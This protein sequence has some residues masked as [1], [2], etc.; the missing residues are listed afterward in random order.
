[1]VVRYAPDAVKGEFVN[2]G[3]VLLDP[4]AGTADVQFTRDWRRVRCLDPLADTA[5]LEAIEAE[6][7]QRLQ[8]G[9]ADRERVL[10]LLRDSFANALQVSA[11]KG[12]LSDAPAQEL[13]R[14]VELYAGRVRPGRPRETAGRAAIV[15]QMRNAFEAAG[16]WPRMFKEVRVAPFTH[17]G[18]PLR[19]DCAYRPNGIMKFFHAVP[20]ATDVDAAKVLAFSYPL[21][22]E[23]VA[24][25]KGWETEL[26]AVVE[27]DLPREDEEIAF[28]IEML[29]RNAIHIAGAQELPRLAE[30]AR[31][32]LRI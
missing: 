23:G 7:H 26:T 21:V 1:M 2:I 17:P 5:M 28:A 10:H 14:L 4:A 18:D 12:L 11:P 16:V 29:Q 3:I 22:R 8:A 30:T 24:R 13:K 32:E 31:R 15:K 25:V 6:V 27:A 9:G 19:L 20:L